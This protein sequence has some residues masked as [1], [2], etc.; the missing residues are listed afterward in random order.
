MLNIFKS[1][2]NERLASPEFRK[3]EDRVIFRSKYD[4]DAHIQN[5]RQDR[6][7]KVRYAF[8]SRPP[9][10]D[11]MNAVVAG[12]EMWAQANPRLMFIRMPRRAPL[13]IK[14]VS[15]YNNPLSNMRCGEATMGTFPRGVIRLS[16][17]MTSHSLIERTVAHEFGHIVGYGHHDEG[18]MWHGY[19]TIDRDDREFYEIPDKRKAR[20]FHLPVLK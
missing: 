16:R 5:Y 11:Y 12:L 8:A 10:T 19:N 4:G 2:S 15:L 14:I 13:V 9:T 3:A 1:K 20:R 7:I 17:S 6:R 18:L